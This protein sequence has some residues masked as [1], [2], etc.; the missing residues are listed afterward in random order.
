MDNDYLLTVKNILSRKGLIKD[1][2]I[3]L[4][5]NDPDILNN[6]KNIIVTP[7]INSE[8]FDTLKNNGKDII[9]YFIKDKNLDNRI[10]THPESDI[11]CSFIAY[12]QD[13]FNNLTI[14]GVGNRIVE[15][16]LSNM[17]TEMKPISEPII[18]KET[19]ITEET[20]LYCYHRPCSNYS[21][22]RGTHYIVIPI[23]KYS[24]DLKEDLIKKYDDK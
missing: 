17:Y 14:E 13:I 18:E 19:K 11:I 23:G 7:H 2:Y 16:I 10:I 9:T 22:G 3:N 21:M 8:L 1:K 5:L 4:L 15:T 24:D 20:G 12:T 6:Y